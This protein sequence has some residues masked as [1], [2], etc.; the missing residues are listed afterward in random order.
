VVGRRFESDL[1]L[2]L[3]RIRAVP[4]RCGLAKLCGVLVGAAS[5]SAATATTAVAQNSPFVTVTPTKNTG[6]FVYGLAVIMA[7][8]GVLVAVALVAAYLRYAPRF[9]RD[10]GTATLRAA[11]V[12]PGREPPRRDVD[13]SQAAPVVVAPPAVPAAQAAAAPAASA[14]AAPAPAQAAPAPAQAAPAPAQAA[15]AP[16]AV[17]AASQ[18]A[19]AAPQAA[20]A[21]AQA[22][23]AAAA[24]APAAAA[25]PKERP[26]VAL[27]QE[28]F[29][30]K[31]A[32]L[33]E[34]G[35]DRRVAEGQARRA[36]MLAA[37]KKA[38]G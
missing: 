13:I 10:E 8:L 27:D 20:P 7:V 2:V 31:L 23:P 34:K 28:V 29:D 14:Q 17:A 18:Q 22:A 1:R 30:A 9:Q 38:E 37:R 19:E 11:P 3:A 6:G 15:P 5:L 21:P 24:S 36:A 16:A 35:T 32:E 4:N 26:E 12:V 33:L 25:P